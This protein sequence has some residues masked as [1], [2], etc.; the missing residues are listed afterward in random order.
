MFAA[1]LKKALSVLLLAAILFSSFQTA[2]FAAYE[3]SY[4]NTGDQAADLVGVAK[5]QLG[6]TESKDGSTKYGEA[7]GNA[8]MEWCGAFIV[9]CADQANISK[10]VIPQN[11]SSNGLK[12]FYESAGLYF[13]SYGHGGM[14]TPKTGDIAFISS[15]NDPNNITHVGIV[16]SCADNTVT[17]IEGN[18]SKR[19]TQVS[20]PETTVKI[21]GFASPAYG[22]RTG[23]YK[24]NETMRLR[25][26]ATTDSDILTLI[27]AGTVVIV[28]KIKNNNWGRVTYDGKTGWMN[29]DYSVFLR[30]LDTADGT[31]INIPENALYLAADISQ[32]NYPDSIDWD[33][34]KSSGVE[35][36]ILR[37]GG[38]GYGYTKE[39]YNDTAFVQ[40]YQ[41][42][43]KAGMHIGVYFFSYAL[44]TSQAKEE[45]KRTI[46]ILKKN[47]C[48]LDMPVFIDIEDHAP[49]DYSHEEAGKTVCTK[50]VNA[51]CNT[52][53]EAGFYPGVYCNK[54]FAENLLNPSAFENR[55][56]WIAQY[57]VAN[58]GY[59]GRY[60]IWQYTSTGNVSGYNG[61]IDLNYVYT[62]FPTLIANAGITG[63]FGKHVP[64]A[65]EI[66]A[67]PT[68]SKEGKRVV[69]CTDCGKVLITESIQKIHTESKKYILLNDTSVQVGKKI[70]EAQTAQLHGED[71]RTYKKTYLPLYN[72]NGGTILTYCTVCSKVL[73]TEYSF[74]GET[75]EKTETRTTAST[76]KT[77]GL[78]TTVC[79]D[80]DKILAQSL[81]PLA[82]HTKG[83]TVLNQATCT[84]SG[85]QNTLC[86]T[87]DKTIRTEYA[88]ASE[89]QF[90]KGVKTSDLTLKTPKIVTYTCTVCGFV[91][92]EETPAPVYGDTDANGQ[93][94]T[95]DA[96]QTLRCALGLTSFKALQ[97]VAG[98]I[99]NSGGINME[100]ARFILRLALELDTPEELM[101][102]YY[103]D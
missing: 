78:S 85:K 46:S 68:C 66:T 98:D 65:W 10:S 49:Q 13:L 59:E 77:E 45:A 8:T 35:A 2:V 88:A 76:C 80:C 64:G 37:I 72:K 30:A 73:S 31:V 51:F 9:W 34:L 24:L 94:T 12:D 62:D 97:K 86:A 42:A 69:K 48:V 17:T 7:L 4:K 6:Y 3:N 83:N 102:K 96:R 38:R 54:Y 39:L 70:T 91:K 1:K 36:V 40:N 22:S 71:E 50:V 58:C 32:W 92:T 74:P 75:H 20:Y 56:V 81:L 28:T 90:G 41:N 27:P 67:E 14:Y 57:G 84:K 87:C 55:A 61:Y 53:E 47:D 52:I 33:K 79:T 99:D 44:T 15:T 82:E 26:K 63:N 29:L 89:H 93:V 101:A 103:K 25:K 95:E 43:V 11:P 60:D 19:V 21:V 16:L 5:T 100:D 23:Y 18:Y